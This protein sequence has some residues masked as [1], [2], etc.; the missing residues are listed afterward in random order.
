VEL[1]LNQLGGT[2]FLVENGSNY[3]GL[4]RIRV[5]GVHNVRNALAAIV[6]A[7]VLDIKFATVRR[8]L[9]E[10]GG[11]GRR[12]QI[13][14]EVKDVIVIDDYA[15]HPTEIQVTLAAARQR[16]PGRRIWAV[17]QPHTFSRTERL[18]GEFA[19]SFFDADRV[20]AL[21][22]FHSREYDPH[23]I[24]TADVLKNMNHPNAH[25]LA[26]IGDAA[27]FILDRISPGDVIITLAAG[28]GN[29]VGQ[30]VLAGL[31][32]RIS[33]SVLTNE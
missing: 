21:D 31:A 20:V 28:D 32:N 9:A 26:G 2:D 24:D 15:H 23:N 8:A 11:I 30:A 12:F 13:V 1:R 19:T 16:F 25:H 7:S 3:N 29:Q 18:I 10:F 14:G 5:P 27:D 17:W 22:I 33:G 6:V 4:I